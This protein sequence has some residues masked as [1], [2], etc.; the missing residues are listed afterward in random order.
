MAKIEKAAP[1]A[2]FRHYT[3]IGSNGETLYACPMEIKT[4]ADLD[5]YGI[6]WDACRT[7]NFNGSEK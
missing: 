6:T 3:S 1:E 7:L 5:N 2:L 4:Q